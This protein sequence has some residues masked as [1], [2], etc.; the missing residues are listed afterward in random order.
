MPALEVLQ[1]IGKLTR[2]SRFIQAKDTIDNVIGAR[3][4]ARTKVLR[5][6]RRLER[7]NDDP[8]RIRSEVECLPI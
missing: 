4:V 7:P 1:H 2:S 3:F 5:L 8:S 6:G